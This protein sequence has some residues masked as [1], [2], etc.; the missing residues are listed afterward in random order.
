MANAAKTQDTL[1]GIIEVDEFFMAYS[2]KGSKQLTSGRKA[3]KRGGMPIKEQRKN[4]SLSYF[5]LTV[6]KI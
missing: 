1:S 3:R 2:E 5:Q 6:V 4:K